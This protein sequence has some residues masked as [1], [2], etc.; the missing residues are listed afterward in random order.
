MNWALAIEHN[1]KLLLRN[2]AWLFTWLGLEVG[3]SVETMPRLKRLTALFV[4]RPSESAFRRVLLVAVFVRGVVGPIFK[5]RAAPSESSKRKTEGEKSARAAML[6]FKLTDQRKP[7]DL[8]PDK[9][10]YASGPGPWITDPW[11]DDPIYDRSALYAYQERINCPPPSSDDEESAKALCLRMNALMAALSDLDGQVLRMAKLHARIAR[12]SRQ[13]GKFPLRV[14]RPGLP[15]GYRQRQ[16]H[17][18]DE[19]LAECHRLALMAEHEL[20]PPDTS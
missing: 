10:K 1:H 6:P 5:R 15:P 11:S 16:K 19:V 8:Y 17:E 14:M 2:V 7:F 12:Q 20:K 3:E 18:V 9:P 4:L 13:V